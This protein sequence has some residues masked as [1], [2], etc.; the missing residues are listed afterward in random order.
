MG[1]HTKLGFIGLGT[2]GQPMALNLTRAGHPLTVW[3]RSPQKG[4]PLSDA[5]ATIVDD[6]ADVF[7]RSDVVF[8]MLIDSAAVDH[9]LR[10]GTPSFA[11]QLSC[12][13]VVNMSSVEPHYSSG[14]EKDIK[15]AGGRFVEAP[16]SGSRVPAETGQLV[17]MVAGDLSVVSDVSPLLR[18]MCH[19][20]VFC[21]SAGSGLRMKLAVNIFML[22]LATGLA[23]AVHFAD[24]QK[25]DRQLLQRILNAGPMSSAFSRIKLAKLVADDF[26]AQALARD[27]C[28]STRLITD[29][30]RDAHIAA[31]LMDVC[32]ELYEETVA[33]GHGSS[34]MRSRSSAQSRHD[35]MVL[36]RAH[37]EILPRAAR[38]SRARSRTRTPPRSHS[39]I[40]SFSICRSNSLTV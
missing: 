6:V 3:N 26:S 12:R 8:L 2:M 29:A 17:A 11:A 28:N 27:G 24:R 25:L 16:V 9:V 30:A 5:G 7:R 21:G 10:R 39:M 14:L 31:S 38:M 22:V 20:I 36:R 35:P 33:L 1:S 34:D 4:V 18:P 37:D 19:A 23:E 13:T 32:R 15:D 40:D